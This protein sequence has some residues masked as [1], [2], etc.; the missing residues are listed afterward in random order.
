[1]RLKF[2]LSMVFAIS[3]STGFCASVEYV[4]SSAPLAVE[5]TT[6]IPGNTLKT[7]SYSVSI[8][9]QI[10]DRMIVRIDSTNS[11]NHAI[12]LGVP[13][14]AA[15]IGGN[16][17]AVTWPAGVNKSPTLRGFVFPNG[18][19]VEFVYPKAEAAALAKDNS[20]VVVAMDPRSEGLVA[21]KSLSHDELLIVNLWLLSLTSTG[22][23]NKTPAVL[24]RHYDA[25]QDLQH[26]TVASGVSPVYPTGQRRAA[27]I[28]AQA[29]APVVPKPSVTPAPVVAQQTPVA[30]TA[31]IAQGAPI[32]Q[33]VPQAKRTPV[34]RPER[35]ASPQ[36]AK[37]EEPVMPKATA[38]PARRTPMIAQLPHTAGFLPVVWMIGLLS[39]L[40]AG[41]ARFVGWMTQRVAS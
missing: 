31:T 18:N 17:G 3:S 13:S 22:P 14:T 33:P 32:A 40:G 26:P 27:A 8:V 9:E 5:H 30:S 15:K 28:Q 38:G 1:M 39:V 24:A 16:A 19:A 6:E 37:V 2:F 21:L 7:G 36:V 11:A 29:S 4:G 34:A 12:F 10:A 41:L 25:T 23:D 20:A 35:S